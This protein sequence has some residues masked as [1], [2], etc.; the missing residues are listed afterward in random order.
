[1]ERKKADGLLLKKARAQLKRFDPQ[2]G[3]STMLKEMDLEPGSLTPLARTETEEK[4]IEEVQ[5][6]SLLYRYRNHLVHE[7]R[8]PG[9]GWEIF[10]EDTG[11]PCYHGYVS[12]PRFYLAYP[13]DLFRT[14]A[15]AA[16]NGIES[17]FLE[18]E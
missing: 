3:T 13:V 1:L 4:G 6:R 17:Y 15:N 2:A 8:E 7:F 5:R 16:V 14:I 10:A 9:H 11:Y 18:Y 12:D